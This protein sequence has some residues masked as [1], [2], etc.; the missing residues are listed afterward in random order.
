MLI[1]DNSLPSKI[2]TTCKELKDLDLYSLCPSAK[3]G[4]HSQCKECLNLKAREYRNKNKK[5]IESGERKIPERKFCTGCN[6][7]KSSSLFMLQPFCV[8]GLSAQCTECTKGK[9]SKYIKE[10]REEFTEKHRKYVE[11]NRDHVNELQRGYRADGRYREY[12]KEKGREYSQ[13]HK[14]EIREQKR[15]HREDPE[16]RRRINEYQR[17]YVKRRSEEEPEYKLMVL[18]RR[19][20]KGGIRDNVQSVRTRELLG[21]EV[22]VVRAYLES[23]FYPNPETGELMTW[24]N[25]THYGWNI[26][27]VIPISEFDL[28]LPEEQKKAFHVSNVQPLWFKDH[29]KKH[30]DRSKPIPEGV[31]LES[32]M[33]KYLKWKEEYD[34]SN[35]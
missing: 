13:E 14:D 4:H 12:F 32:L 24:E 25:N 23:Q 31:T 22:S 6:V 8:D 30:T 34:K 29:N 9:R 17:A 28:R 19:R 27:H 10:H 11:K 3:D 35:G 5:A 7:E 18:L 16:V 15:K 26:D 33:A 20:V 21:A 1:G 2:C